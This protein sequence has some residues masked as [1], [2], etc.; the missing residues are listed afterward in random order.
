MA[1]IVDYNQTAED[2][3]SL[4]I[5]VKHSGPQ[6]HAECFN[7]IYERISRVNCVRVQGQNRDIC[8]RFCRSY[9]SEANSWGDFQGH[10]KVLG[11]I[12][13]G[14]C[15]DRSNFTELFTSYQ[16]HKEEYASTVINSRLVAFGMNT[17]G[18]PLLKDEPAVPSYSNM[19]AGDAG[20]NAQCENDQTK[21]NKTISHVET[22]ETNDD[23]KL[24]QPQ[25]GVRLS[26]VPSNLAL[27]SLPS[28]HSSSPSPVSPSQQAVSGFP[29]QN[30]KHSVNPKHTSQ[31]DNNNK[32]KQA[33]NGVALSR[34]SP[35]TMRTSSPNISRSQLDKGFRQQSSNL[36]KE[37]GGSEVVFYPN[38]DAC[39]DI[40]ERIRDFVTSLYFVLE[41]KRL[42]RSFERNEKSVPLCAPFEKK[43]FVGV[44][45]EAK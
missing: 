16:S 1:Q 5:L 21:S 14:K 36:P 19:N 4:L 13:V 43:D 42:D 3:R 34:T 9:S 41:G 11:L 38:L 33:A 27:S 30:D 2:H 18:S 35:K 28:S 39:P 22:D 7:R 37:S 17:D 32:S 26:P 31:Q 23:C 12:T 29:T 10:R 8:V 15:S 44:D 45:T 25:S 40:E 24:Q 20:V 6:L